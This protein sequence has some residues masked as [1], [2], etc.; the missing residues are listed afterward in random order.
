MPGL[1]VVA[2]MLLALLV[3][4]LF[5]LLSPSAWFRL[6]RWL[7]VH[8]TA[9]KKEYGGGARDSNSFISRL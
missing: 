4:A 9:T 7:G 1:I 6:P 3:N 2:I 5:M 8:G